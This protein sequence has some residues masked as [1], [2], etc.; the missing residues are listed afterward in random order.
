M[1]QILSIAP[2][3][4]FNA[5]SP[6][7]RTTRLVRFAGVAGAEIRMYAPLDARIPIRE[8]TPP[9]PASPL[10]SQGEERRT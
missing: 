7:E 2:E 4:P 1:C 3:T 6:L 8:A 5:T 10:V 9:V